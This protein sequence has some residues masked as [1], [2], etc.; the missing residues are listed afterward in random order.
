MYQP[1]LYPYHSFPISTKFPSHRGELC[2]RTGYTGNI[3][4]RPTLTTV[5]PTLTTV[6]PT[7]LYHGKKWICTLGKY[8]SVPPF[9]VCPQWDGMDCRN[10]AVRVDRLGHFQCVQA[11]PRYSGM[12]WTVGTEC[13]VMVGQTGTFPVC[14]VLPMEQWDG[15]NS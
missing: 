15:R 12:G 6:H 8:Q 5:H 7:P 11:F 13:M 9:P 14:P 1:V 2:M 10:R 4:V 3:P